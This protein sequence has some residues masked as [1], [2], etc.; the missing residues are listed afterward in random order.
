[1][2][3]NRTGTGENQTDMAKIGWRRER[4]RRTW[5]KSDRD[6]R[7]SDGQ[8]NG[9]PFSNRFL[10]YSARKTKY[11]GFIYLLRFDLLNLLS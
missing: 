10:D 1:M 6:G 2:V 11:S 9:L 7:E 5:P 4:I 8:I 3:G